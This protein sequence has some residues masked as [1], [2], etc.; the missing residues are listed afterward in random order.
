M[1]H[2]LRTP[3]NAIIGFSDM[4]KNESFKLDAGRK[5]E[6]ARLINDSGR[7]LLSVV[8]GRRTNGGERH[9]GKNEI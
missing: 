6:Y 1:G 8:D 9:A 4:L 5:T 7:H 2:E 3:L